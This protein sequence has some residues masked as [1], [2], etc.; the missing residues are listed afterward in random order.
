MSETS[1]KAPK[2]MGLRVRQPGFAAPMVVP[3]W[4]G[5][6]R[7]DIPTPVGEPGDV[8]GLDD[9][10]ARLAADEA[11]IDQAEKDWDQFEAEKE[12]NGFRPHGPLP[13][14]DVVDVD[15]DGNPVVERPAPALELVAIKRGDVEQA[16]A[17]IAD[18]L[19]TAA[20]G[21]VAHRREKLNE[22]EKDQLA[23]DRAALKGADA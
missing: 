9:A 18:A 8:I 13:F 17:A 6:Y 4:P 20:N 16:E 14:G 11:R 5:F 2:R 22:A 15:A 7:S 12:A 10:K 23:D 3:G 1:A 21:V 19:T